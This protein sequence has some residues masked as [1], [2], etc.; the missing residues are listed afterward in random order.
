[1]ASLPSLLVPEIPPRSFEPN[2]SAFHVRSRQF[3]GFLVEHLRRGKID[4]LLLISDCDLFYVSTA[5][6][7]CGLK[8]GADILLAGFDNYW[9]LC[10]ERA[11]E[12]AVPFLTVDKRDHEWGAAMVQLLLDRL[13]HRLPPHPKT[14][15]ITPKIVFS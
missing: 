6:R 15:W 8:P 12:P 4:A 14:R 5:C 7:L 2:A 13:A 11:L 3:A 1:V 10:W 9:P